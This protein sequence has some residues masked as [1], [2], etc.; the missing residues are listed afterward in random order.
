MT[1]LTAL[2][3]RI[4]KPIRAGWITAVITFASTALTILTSVLPE[5]ASAISSRNFT[6]FYDSLSLASTAI[7]S[8]VTAFLAGLVNVVYRWLKPIEESYRTMPPG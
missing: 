5:L 2:W 8:A 3:R 6:P 1:Q 4:P 7:L